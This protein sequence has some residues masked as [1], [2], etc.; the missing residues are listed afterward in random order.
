MA[1]LI[2]FSSR[3]KYTLKDANNAALINN[4]FKLKALLYLRTY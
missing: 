4:Y 2:S 3:E 1:I